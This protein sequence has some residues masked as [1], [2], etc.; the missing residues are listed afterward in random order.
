M[1]SPRSTGPRSVT[2]HGVP[3]GLERWE[4]GQFLVDL[5]ETLVSER[6]QGAGRELRPQ[7]SQVCVGTGAGEP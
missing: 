1:S 5:V 3:A 2:V 7:T 4:R 6:G